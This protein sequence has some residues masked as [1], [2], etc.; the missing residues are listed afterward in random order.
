MF[1]SRLTDNF[2]KG[3]YRIDYLSIY[4]NIKNQNTYFEI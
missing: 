2:K 1:F 3:Y 4:T